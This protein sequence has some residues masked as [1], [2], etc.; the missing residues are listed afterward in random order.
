MRSL[1]ALLKMSPYFQD[2]HKTGYIHLDTSDNITWTEEQLALVSQSITNSDLS[3]YPSSSV[4]MFI[5]TLQKTFNHSKDY[6]ILLSNGATDSLNLFFQAT[7]NVEKTIITAQPT[8]FIYEHFS[9]VYYCEHVGIPLKSDFSLPIEDLVA[10][11][12]QH[13]NPVILLSSPNNPTGNCYNLA[14]IEALLK[15]T[16]ATVIVDETYC[17]YAKNNC[18]SLLNHYDNLIILRSFSKVG[19]AGL[20]LGYSITTEKQF[21][22][23]SRAYIPFQTNN[24]SLHFAKGLLESSS[25]FFQ[26]I[27]AI[28]SERVRLYEQLSELKT[29]L[30]YPSLTN[31]ICI[32]HSAFTCQEL[33]EYLYKEKIITQPF[34]IPHCMENCLRINLNQPK[35]HDALI[36][37]LALL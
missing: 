6:Y 1:S 16:N 30:V 36:K 20:R 8:Y 12:F 35:D 14:D 2:N 19:M 25:V 21:E 34:H 5:E 7:C 33:Y 22:I 24:L 3:R 23:L 4:D 15:R 9:Q 32:S 13:K 11:T 10:H 17:L 37:A 27:E 18:E 29:L 26:H 31:F 28:I